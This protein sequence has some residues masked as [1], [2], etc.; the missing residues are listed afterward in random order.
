M[1]P[2]ILVVDDD[3]ENQ[4]LIRVILQREGYRVD[5]QDSGADGL[6]ALQ[7]ERFDLVVLDVMMPDMNGFEVYRRLQADVKTRG[8]P[9]IMLTAMAQRKDYEQAAQLGVKDYITKP[10]EP[11][12]L[13][14]RVRAALAATVREG[15]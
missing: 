7:R 13:I 3:P 2:Q 15:D 14:A 9:V 1:T 12:D 10:F 11:D 8:I 4:L 5:V 6:A